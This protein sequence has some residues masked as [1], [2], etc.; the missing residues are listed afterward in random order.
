MKNTAM[1]LLVVCL[2]AV[3]LFGVP[4]KVAD[5]ITKQPTYEMTGTEAVFL[6]HLKE[7]V[8]TSLNQYQ[9]EKDKIKADH[10]WP[11]KIQFDDRNDI[12]SMPQE[13]APKSK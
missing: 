12:W 11:D 9:A 6:L 13:E 1:Y 7:Q 5:K 8:V 4:K 3:A 10:K 2:L